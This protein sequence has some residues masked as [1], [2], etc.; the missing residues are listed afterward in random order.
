VE[1][2][3]GSLSSFRPRLVVPHSSHHMQLGEANRGMV[4]VGTVVQLGL[5]LAGSRVQGCDRAPP[6]GRLTPLSGLRRCRSG[7]GRRRGDRRAAGFQ[8]GRVANWNRR[9]PVGGLK[10][11]VCSSPC[12]GAGTAA[13]T[14]DRGA[15]VRRAAAMA[16][17]RGWGSGQWRRG[18]Q[19]RP[20]GVSHRCGPGPATPAEGRHGP[21]TDGSGSGR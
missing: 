2:L 10:R 21:H 14:A 15:G 8:G 3:V 1:R 16:T 7:P 19:P 9:W 13:V 17:G 12:C 4:L 5:R 11:L 18:G 6:A 20:A